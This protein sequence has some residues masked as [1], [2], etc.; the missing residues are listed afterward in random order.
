V[1]ACDASEA[2]KTMMSASASE[3]TH[4]DK[5]ACGISWRLAGV[6]MIEGRTA[7]TVIPVFFNSSARLSVN[8]WTADFDAKRGRP[9]HA[10]S[11]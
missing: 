6:S 3:V 8:R 10:R 9:G 5:S 2:R 7:L 1:I 11:R 4:L